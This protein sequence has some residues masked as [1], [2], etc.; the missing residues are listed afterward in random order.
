MRTDLL[1]PRA[2]R[3]AALADR[4]FDLLVI[5]GGIT[6]AGIA[7]DAARR[8]L[9]TALIERDDF[10][11]GTSS[12]SSRLVHGGVRYLE[13]GYFHLVFE[14]SRERRRLLA[15]APHLVHP[16]R[17]TW[18]VYRGA[19]VPR[20]KL[21]AGLTMYD[22]LALFRN[23]G[24]HRMLGPRGVAESEPA[25]AREG[26]V[27][28][29]A[30]WDAATDDA[31]LTLANVLDAAANGASVLNHA[32]VVALT[33]GRDGRV[34][35]A[36]VRD[37]RG[38]SEFRVGARL[39]VNATGPWTDAITRLERPSAEP[40]LRGTKGVHVAVPSE[41]VGNFGA[42]T[43]L[44]PD[45]GRVMFTLPA[46]RHTII[47]TTDTPTDRHP[48]EVRAS[49]ADVRYLL[50]ACNR[51]FPDAR[52]VEDDVVAAWA[53]I[54]PLVAT[55][56]GSTP[57]SASR[58]HLIA[59]SDAGVL[60]VTGGKLTT[61]REM[62]E[63]CVD[64]AVRHL[65][66]TARACDTTEARL[67]GDRLPPAPGDVVLVPGLEWRERDVEHAVAV[68]YAETVADVLVRRTHVAFE[69]RDHGRSVAPAVAR[70]IGALLGWTDA[71]IADAVTD[72]ERDIARMFAVDD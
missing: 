21:V 9:A 30:Y 8:G 13:H 52:L 70:R 20:W 27:G 49:R 63:Q 71:G 60:T 12:R 38:G 55:K 61:Y 68:E 36:V 29:A 32:A 4:D 26:L 11:A 51:F 62:A 57:A 19:R 25:L 40:T 34:D 67:P 53:G 50:Q 5:G 43:M 48:E 58:E 69:T 41:R 35:G 45:D 28:G 24:R 15:L 54:R 72:Y 7:R 1:P 39:I 18:P 3:L 47:G 16:L 56:R 17:F 33:R 31:R 23:V 2:R 37:A 14:A 59:F 42:V 10:G 65:A 22:A 66:I 44:S 64:I 6:G 46:G